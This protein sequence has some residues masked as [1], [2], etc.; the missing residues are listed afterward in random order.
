MGTSIRSSGTS[1]WPT[2]CIRVRTKRWNLSDG[3]SWHFVSRLFSPS[4]QALFSVCSATIRVAVCTDYVLWGK[5]TTWTWPWVRHAGR[6]HNNISWGLSQPRSRWCSVRRDGR[7]EV[8]LCLCFCFR[9]ISVMDVERPDFSV[10]L[11]LFWSC[12]Y[13]LPNDHHSTHC[14]FVPILRTHAVSWLRILL[15]TFKG[16]Y[17]APQQCF[18]TIISVS[19]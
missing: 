11:P 16:P 17:S 8:Q 2:P 5:D 7:S 4:S 1:S 12:E 10:A 19:A 14:C 3:S 6:G 15:D 18:L 13:K 9:G